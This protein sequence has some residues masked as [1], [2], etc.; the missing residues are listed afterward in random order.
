MQ[1]GVNRARIFQMSHAWESSES[2]VSEIKSRRSRFIVAPISKK[3]AIFGEKGGFFGQKRPFWGRKW[4][5][6]AV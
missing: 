5:K 1:T 3:R 6:F 4:E 2:G